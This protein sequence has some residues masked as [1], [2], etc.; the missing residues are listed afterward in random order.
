MQVLIVH[1]SAWGNTSEV[2]AAIG[3]G[4]ADEGIAPQ[5]SA[6]Q[7]APPLD[8]I[9]AD[10]LIVGAPTHAFGLS[11]EA[12]RNDARQRGGDLITTGVR[13]WLDA[14]PISLTVT[15]FDTHIRHPK[16]PGHAS[17][18]AAKKLKKLGCALFVDPESF[19]VE[20]YEGP[21]SPGEHDRAREW[22]RELGRLLQ[23]RSK[24]T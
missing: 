14:E 18:K 3:E 6:V 8:Q 10:L 4:L 1:E 13:E 20:D 9:H 2:A 19:D 23:D 11:R 21:L 5:I 15:T 17:K 24:T 22:G 7:D 12:T 16:L